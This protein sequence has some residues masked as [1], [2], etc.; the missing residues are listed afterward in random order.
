MW[1]WLERQSWKGAEAMDESIH[2][3]KEEFMYLSVWEKNSSFEVTVLIFN[4]Y[5]KFKSPIQKGF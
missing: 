5:E 3:P 4:A 1:A 2:G